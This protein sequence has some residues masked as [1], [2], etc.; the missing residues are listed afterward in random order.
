MDKGYYP[1]TNLKNKE[2]N[3]VVMPISYSCKQIISTE[4]TTCPY[5]IKIDAK[6]SKECFSKTNL[7]YCLKDYPCLYSR[8]HSSI[9]CSE[10]NDG[11]SQSFGSSNCIE[12]DK[13]MSKSFTFMILF[14]AALLFSSKVLLI[15]Y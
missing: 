2:I 13:C 12:N 4:N 8:N 10:C 6:D 9:M 7:L 1:L 3:T 14:I 11:F 15:I 5:Y